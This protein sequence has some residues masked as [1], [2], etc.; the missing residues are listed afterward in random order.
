VTASRTVG[1]CKI[2]VDYSSPGVKGRKMFGGMIPFGEV[3]RTGANKPT[4]LEISQD[5]KFGDK[6]VPAGKYVLCTIPGKDSWS[7]ILNKNT[8]QWGVYGYKE[9]DDQARVTVKP[10]AIEP[11][12]CL[13]IRIT[14]KSRS[15]AEL[16]ILFEKTKV[17]VPITVDVDGGMDKK[18]EEALAKNPNNTMAMFEAADYY[19][20]SNRNLEKS[21]ELFG[22]VCEN[23][24]NPLVAVAIWR[25]GQV[26]WKLGK[27]DAAMKSFDEAAELAKN[28]KGFEGVAKEIAAMKASLTEKGKS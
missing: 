17:S 4:I 6:E 27:K 28:S 26:E 14:P 12:E 7:V 13:D 22:K 23:K 20:Q 8:E 16:E 24:S 1:N 15:S 3:W 2:S 25:R 9:S 18:I 5:I 21:L 19:L 10:A 11:M